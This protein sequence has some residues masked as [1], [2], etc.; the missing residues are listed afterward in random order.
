M[1]LKSLIF[2]LLAFIFSCK[3]DFLEIKSDK[4]LV[5]PTTLQDFQA[6]LDN[7]EVM[8]ANMPNLGEISADDYYV[9]YPVWNILSQPKQKNAYIWAKDV[10]AG[11]NAFLDWNYRYQQVFYANNVL[12]GLEKIKDV[13]DQQTYNQIKGSALFYR[14]YSFYQLAQVF[15]Q[16]YVSPGNNTGL[17][18]PLR[19]KSD[20]N[21]PT[22]RSTV[23]ETY[24]QILS[25]LKEAGRLLPITTA[26][27]TRPVKSAADA[28][29]SRVY[30]LMQDYNNSLAFAETVIG[31]AHKLIDY[32]V[33]NV[34]AAYPL[35]Q[36]NTEVIFQSTLVSEQILLASRLI[37]DST[38]YK[39]YND[40]D[41]RKLLYFRNNN[42]N[43][44]FKGSYDGSSVYFNGLALDEL[45]LN[46][47]ECL[48]R[49]GMTPEA[50]EA[51]NNLL[52]NRWRTGK[53]VP[54]TASNSNNALTII[55][56]ERR[57]ELLYR[58]IRWSDLRRLNLSSSTSKT[59][60]RV[61]NG[62]V[63][64]LKPNSLNYVLPIQNDVIQMSGIPQN[65]R[66]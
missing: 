42:G 46:K 45:Y 2:I 37:I 59:L 38:L 9:S 26:Y 64:E 50:M 17:G 39:S 3:K 21:L 6:L 29:L 15:C 32:N 34:A 20:I 14:A 19:L 41:L 65:Q 30:L 22:K 8:N 24:Q 7:T 28:M 18:I 40:D 57:K 4:K 62:Q 53:Y 52:K 1:K 43:M 47:A 16:T 33:L 49:N 13:A 36:Y 35:P 54:L 5:I 25:D 10:Y 51:L 61:L 12:E 66:D 11:T 27:K 48:A 56:Q 31:S 58:G 55:L 60:Y 44:T 23:E 63:Y